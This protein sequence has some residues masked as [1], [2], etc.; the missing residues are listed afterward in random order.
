MATALITGGTSGIAAFARAYAARG[1][2]LV[3]VACNPDRLAE[4]ATILKDRYQAA[5]ETIPADLAQRDD[6]QRVA[7]RLASVEQPVEVL[8]NNA[9]FAEQGK[10]LDEDITPQ[11]H[12]LDV[13]VRAVMI[14]SATAGRVAPTW[15]R[16]D[17]QR[18]QHSRFHGPWQLLSDQGVRHHLHGGASREL[19]GSGVSAVALCPGYVRTEFHQRASIRTGG[20][21]G[22]M[23]LDADAL[24]AECLKDVAAG[25]VISI[26]S[27]RYKVMILGASTC[28]A[29]RDSESLPTSKVWTPLALIEDRLIGCPLVA[30]ARRCTP[31]R[32]SWHN[33]GC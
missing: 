1:Y 14:L 4:T 6:V 21:P 22:P 3:L 26:P 28:T 30:I 33:G 8:V 32:G 20:I 23:W 19:A 2:D 9:G 24:V 17:H 7:D 29:K 11:E 18:V 25:K 13:M 10:L 31:A 5:V 16:H 15:C 27:F 12:A